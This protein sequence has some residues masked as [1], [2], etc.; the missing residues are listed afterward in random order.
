MS[1]A[2]FVTFGIM[3]LLVLAALVV[4]F[5][6]GGEDPAL[7]MARQDWS[8]GAC[9]GG[10]GGGLSGGAVGAFRLPGSRQPLA[11]MPSSSQPSH[12]RLPEAV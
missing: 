4:Q 5:T 10:G 1:V 3:G 6:G 12:V 2:L 8:S 7:S 9:A 11:S